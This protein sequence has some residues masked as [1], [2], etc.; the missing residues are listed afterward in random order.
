MEGISLIEGKALQGIVHR[1]ENIERNQLALMKQL[2]QLMPKTS[3]SNLPEFI[4]IQDACVKYHTSHV[5]INN[6]IKLFKQFK[7]RA[8]DRLRSGI[9]YLINEAELQEALRIKGIYK[10]VINRNKAFKEEEKEIHP[11]LH[12]KK[13]KPL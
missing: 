8:I 1:L 10:K 13:A 11:H 4:S 3:Q 9:F 7:N 2:Q 12:P 5:T 6:K